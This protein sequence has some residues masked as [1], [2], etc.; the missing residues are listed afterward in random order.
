MDHWRLSKDGGSH[1]VTILY[2]H[3]SLHASTELYSFVTWSLLNQAR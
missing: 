1:T 2:H 3:Y